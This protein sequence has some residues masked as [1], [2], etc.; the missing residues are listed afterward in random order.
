MS[1]DIKLSDVC[2]AYNLYKP[3][4]GKSIKVQVIDLRSKVILGEILLAK[5]NFEKPYPELQAIIRFK[6]K[7]EYGFI[8]PS[9]WKHWPNTF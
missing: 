3:D 7:K 6:F 4:E 9:K 1:G 5:K 2:I 8:L